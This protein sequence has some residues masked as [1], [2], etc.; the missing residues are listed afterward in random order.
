MDAIEQNL[1]DLHKLCDKIKERIQALGMND[2]V[3]FAS[4]YF[5]EDEDEWESLDGE[6]EDLD[7]ARSI[8]FH[9]KY[10]EGGDSCFTT[11]VRRIKI[12]DE[13]L[14][15]DLEEQEENDWSCERIGFFEDQT[16]DNITDEAHGDNT[17]QAIC[18]LESILANAFGDEECY[19]KILELNKMRYQ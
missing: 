3:L 17:S 8:D 10:A 4:D 7:T 6:L 19:Q 2:Y 1:Q 15:F 9:V 18:C 16:I 11:Y 12:I 13:K 5:G 14:V